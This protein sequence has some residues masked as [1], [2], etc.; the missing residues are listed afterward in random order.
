MSGCKSRREVAA[1]TAQGRA[2]QDILE[3]R[4]LRAPQAGVVVDIRTVTPGAVI[5]SGDPLM[6]IVPDGDRLVVETRLPLDAID[7][8]YVGR[9][10]KVTLTAYHRAKGLVVKGEVIYVS[11]DLIEDERDG[12]S[13][14]RAR[15]SLDPQS[16]ALLP[17]IALTAGMPVEVAVQTG[18]RRA[19][20]YL[21]EPLMRHFGRALREE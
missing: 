6:E 1:L 19:G 9:T 13:Y 12:S 20:D 10:A 18:E 11:A 4:K 3:R 5:R 8:V 21:L 7:T 14:F 15:V 17:D 2:A 16:L